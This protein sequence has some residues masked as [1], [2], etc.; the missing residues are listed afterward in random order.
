[1]LVDA[2]TSVA[3]DL[4][5]F[6]LVIAGECDDP[7]Q[8]FPDGVPDWVTFHNRQIDDDAVQGLFDSARALVLPYRQSSQSGV[9]PLALGFGLPV[10]V[11]D[12]GGLGEGISEGEN[13]LIVPPEN[14]PALATALRS[15]MTDETL[16]DSMLKAASCPM[17]TTW[18]AGAEQ[19]LE[20]YRAVAHT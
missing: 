5:G 16:A 15:L 14:A 13:G 11:S 18:A 10:I 2:A 1:V 7:A 6:Q 20:I 17:E 9:A 8:Y 4:D 12:I 3:N 19:H